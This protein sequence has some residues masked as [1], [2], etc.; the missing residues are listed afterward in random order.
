MGYN[1]GSDIYAGLKYGDFSAKL[2]AD[3]RPV[4]AKNRAEYERELRRLAV[5]RLMTSTGESI[6]GVRVPQ[7][8]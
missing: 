2:G 7:H 4:V 5:P 3:L 1:Y 8:S 6:Y